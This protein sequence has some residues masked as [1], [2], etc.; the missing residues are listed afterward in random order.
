[1]MNLL[2]NFCAEP[3]KHGWAGLYP[4]CPLKR[5]SLFR[6]LQVLSKSLLSED[7]IRPTDPS[8]LLA[9]KGAEMQIKGNLCYIQGASSLQKD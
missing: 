1:M 5:V 2:M 9:G 4:Y 6:P 3:I 7:F 8:E